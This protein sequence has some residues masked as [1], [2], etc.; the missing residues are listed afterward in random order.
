[1]V[2]SFR[3]TRPVSLSVQL[4]SVLHAEPLSSRYL[5]AEDVLLGSGARGKVFKAFSV[6]RRESVACKV[7]K[8]RDK[9]AL[10]ELVALAQYVPMHS[11]LMSVTD[12]F[13]EH[14]SVYF[15]SELM[16]GGDLC[17]TIMRS[18]SFSESKAKLFFYRMLQGVHALH[19][20]GIMHRDIKL[21]NIFL[22]SPDD[23]STARLGDFGFAVAV[24]CTTGHSP[25]CGCLEYSAPEVVLSRR[26]DGILYDCAVD[27]WSLGV[28]LFCVL[29][30]GFPFQDDDTLQLRQ[31]VTTCKFNFDAPV[32]EKIS[33]E[34]KSVIS[35]LIVVD[36]AE[37]LTAA[38]ALQHPW[39]QEFGLTPEPAFGSGPESEK[40]RQIDGS[41][42]DDVESSRQKFGRL[43]ERLFSWRGVRK[44]TEQQPPPQSQ[45]GSSRTRRARLSLTSAGSPVAHQF[46]AAHGMLRTHSLNAV[47]H[48][49]RF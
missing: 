30:G 16:A 4:D 21:D 49:G 20:R 12:V 25:R 44:R 31:D 22:R 40:S 8:L 10:S 43:L 23:I 48:A 24:G 6:D 32:W 42:E 27:M 17:N 9:S 26:G 46:A 11:S 29:S 38:Q 39:F 15:I 2:F 5:L 41:E 13:I 18:G 35:Q 36:P 3:T 14:G 34:A 7:V 47:Q 33:L 45:R 19:S 1:M 37:R 28:V